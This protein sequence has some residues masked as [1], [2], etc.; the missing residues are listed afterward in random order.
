MVSMSR[1][2]Q[3]RRGVPRRT[4]LLVGALVALTLGGT[5]CGGRGDDEQSQAA[6]EAAVEQRI[7]RERREAARDA[8]QEERIKQ[9]ERELRA[10]TTGSS[11]PSSS[12]ATRSSAP[13]AAS[14]TPSGATRSGGGSRGDWP[15]GSGYTVVL[16]SET[17]QQAARAAQRG[18]SEAGL[19]AG[20][21]RSGDYSSLRSG[22]W[23]VFSGVY[24]SSDS[25][26]A[27]QTRARSLGF[28]DAY[29]RFVAP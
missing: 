10:K 28:A 4:S 13:G 5:A 2:L 23:V 3:P 9:L 8:R 7:E 1:S 27:R 15:G 24:S 19:D 16:A 6:R 25:A 20:V 21:L 12:G 17:S 29:V 11:T 14:G 26:K 18:A 22:Y